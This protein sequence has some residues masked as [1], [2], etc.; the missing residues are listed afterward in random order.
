MPGENGKQGVPTGAITM[1]QKPPIAKAPPLAVISIVVAVQRFL[2]RLSRKLMPAPFVVLDLATHHWMS[3]SLHAV[4]R[5]G[6]PDQLKDGPQSVARLAETSNVHEES[7]YRVLR[8]LARND[9][10]KE[11]PQRTFHLSPLSRV[12]IRDEP[13]SV[14]NMVRQTGSWWALQNWAHLDRVLESG[15][16][17]FHELFGT[18]LW[19]YFEDNPEDGKVFHR[20]MVELTRQVAGLVAAAYDFSQFRTLVD[21]GGGSGELIAVLLSEYPA[22]KGINFD[23]P[24]ALKETA[25]TMEQYGVSDRCEILEGNFF[26]SVPAGHDAYLMKNIAHEFSDEKLGKPLELCKQAMRPDSK[27]I[28]VDSVVSDANKRYLEFLDLQMMLS[29]EYGLE[30]TRLQF[31]R[32]FDMYGFVLEDIKPTASPM[33]VL[34]A[35]RA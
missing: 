20:S 18:D 4:A 16:P 3:A 21:L 5:L 10:F 8:A 17:I 29:S 6:I 34:V 35:R 27:L 11:R 13:D 31:E 23:I 1:D 24:Q 12:L 9:I 25:A 33:S 19:G 32:L 28:I 7:L 15:D 2:T 30:R 14:H 26:E 22:L